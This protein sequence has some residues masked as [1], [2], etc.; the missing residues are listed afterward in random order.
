MRC[1]IGAWL[2]NAFNAKDVG[3]VSVSNHTELSM[4]VC[5]LCRDEQSAG[6]LSD[7]IRHSFPPATEL[8]VLDN[9][10]GEWDCY[11]AIRHFLKEAQ[12]DLII[13]MHDD[14]EFGDLSSPLLLERI[15]EIS[16]KDR[17]ASL[18]GIA[19]ISRKDQ[20]GI[21]HFYDEQGER[22]WG[23]HNGGEASS[24]DECFL[25][26]KN[27]RGV[28]VSEGLEGYH[29]YGTDLC[30]NTMRLGLS[31]YVIDYPLIHKS[32]GS[33][34]ENFFEARD[35]FEEHLQNQWLD[36]FVMTT[37]TVFNGS[38]SRLKQC[39]AFALSLVLLE[40]PR[41]RDFDLA[42]RCILRRGFARLGRLPFLLIILVARL[43]MHYRRWITDVVWWRQ[44]WRHRLP[45]G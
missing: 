40:S 26:I 31:C 36:R 2:S 35:R 9:S 13:V 17:S 29:F 33:L 6:N 16:I 37:C 12:G 44:N 18:F 8:L 5:C 45:R 25:V 23:F 39:W 7:R 21:G 34:N 3:I 27:R 15:R 1:G 11:G 14:I 41:H 4:T 38:T 42:R 43:Q 20:R 10:A 32:A 22:N 24:L 28:N 19:G 30:L